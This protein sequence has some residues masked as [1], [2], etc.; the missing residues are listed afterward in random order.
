MLLTAE[1]A[2][3]IPLFNTPPRRDVVEET[4]PFAAFVIEDARPPAD[5]S[6]DC[7]RLPALDTTPEASEPTPAA[8]PDA[9]FDTTPNAVCPRLV[10][11]F[12][13]EPRAPNNPPEEP[14]C[15]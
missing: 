14:L 9:T 13:A 7:A 5:E 12:K 1:N 10:A 2:D 8:A 3:D 15:P 6:A 11:L 4:A